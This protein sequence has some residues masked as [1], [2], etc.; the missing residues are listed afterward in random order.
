[1]K[2]SPNSENRSG[3]IPD[4]NKRMIDP[5]LEAAYRNTDYWVDDAPGEPFAIRVDENNLDLDVLL[6]ELGEFHWA[7][8]TAC[9]PK[10]LWLSDEENAERMRELEMAVERR[11]LRCFHGHGQGRDD[12]WP[13]EP[14]LLL[15][16]E[17]AIPEAIELASE[18]EQNAIVVG[19]LGEPARLVW[20]S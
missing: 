13:A 20:I 6:T 2:A 12:N 1:L 9:N 4:Y 18:F 3:S 14:S 11:G 16:G 8:V 10:S 19:Q 5:S 15:V 7:F 17:S